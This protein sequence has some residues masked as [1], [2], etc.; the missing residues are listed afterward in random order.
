MNIKYSEIKALRDIVGDDWREFVGMHPFSDSDEFCSDGNYRMIAAGAID[1]IMRE[2]LVNDEYILGCFNAE[3]L[4]KVLGIDEDVI[5]AMQAAEAYEA[6]GRLVI[7][8]GKIEQLQ[9]DY[10]AADGYGHHFSHYDFSEEETA[11]GG[12]QYYIFRVN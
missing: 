2:E 6:V 5:Q 11:L 3:F 10:A 12:Q 1:S 8:M 9:Q 7:S 4:A